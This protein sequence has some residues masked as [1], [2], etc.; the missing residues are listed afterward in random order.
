MAQS[1]QGICKL[2]MVTTL[3]NEGDTMANMTRVARNRGSIIPI[4]NG[5]LTNA[6][7][8]LMGLI[9]GDESNAW[10]TQT[11]VRLT[12][13][14]ISPSPDIESKTMVRKL[15]RNK[16]IQW[17]FS[18]V[19]NSHL[20]C[21]PKVLF[22]KPH[23]IP[24]S[25][26]LFSCRFMRKNFVLLW[27]RRFIISWVLLLGIKI[28]KFSMCSIHNLLWKEACRQLHHASLN[29]RVESEIGLKWQGWDA[30][31]SG[32]IRWGSQIWRGGIGGV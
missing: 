15:V 27:Y 31:C 2:P 28:E 7:W 23:F 24:T 6:W 18:T 21:L 12:D 19:G 5:C 14:P 20:Y 8:G 26:R 30:W 13:V 17:Q 29:K 25:Y 10:V 9:P 3:V 16:Y 22:Q 11:Y 1:G 4:T 32:V